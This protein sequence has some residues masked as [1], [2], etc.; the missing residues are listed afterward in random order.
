MKFAYIRTSTRDQKASLAEQER[1][2]REA[3]CTEVFI[4]ERS[5]KSA[6]NRPELQRMLAKVRDGDVV[7]TTKLIDSA[8]A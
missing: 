5:G 3:G 4:E 6:K 2:L 8:G 1:R 7:V